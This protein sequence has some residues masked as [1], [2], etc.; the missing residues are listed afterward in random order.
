MDEIP[1]NKAEGRSIEELRAIANRTKLTRA[2]INSICGLMREFLNN[3]EVDKLDPQDRISMMISAM[4]S[5]WVGYGFYNF[6]M[7]SIMPNDELQ[8]IEQILELE[9]N[10]DNGTEK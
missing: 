8:N 10:L 7:T 4:V 2:L 3:P 5:V 1:I 6:E 9:D